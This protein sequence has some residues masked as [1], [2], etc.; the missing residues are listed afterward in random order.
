MNIWLVTTGSSDVQLTNNEDWNDWYRTIKKSIQRLPFKPTRATDDENEPYRLPARVLGIAY[1]RL[2]EAI[3]PNLT[4]PLLDGFTQELK[5][6]A[7][8]ITQIIVLM[9]DQADV[10]PES[11]RDTNRSP[12]W[13]DTCLLYPILE[14]YFCEHFPEALLT[15]LLLKPDSVDRG[16]DNWDAVLG[17]VQREIRSLN[18]EPETVYVSHQAGTPAISSAVQ[19]ASL[20]K[21]GDRVKFLVSSEYREDRTHTIASSKY[22]GA[23]RLQEAKA[24]LDRYDYA[25]VKVLIGGALDTQTQVFLDAGIQW[26][27]ADFQSFRD[28]LLNSNFIKAEDFKWWSFGYESAYLAVIRHRQGSIVDALFHSFRSVEGLI[29]IWAETTYKDYIVY[30]KKG[31]PQVTE[32]IKDILPEYWERIEEKQKKWLTEQREK[33]QQSIDKGQEGLPLSTG[34]FSQSLY[35][36]FETVRPESK[37]NKYIKTVLYSAKDERNQQFHRLLGLQE[38]NLFQAWKA[39]N[40]EEWNA[41]LLG[42]L[43]FIAQVDSTSNFES[44]KSTSFMAKVHQ[45]LKDTIASL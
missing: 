13:Q 12:Y 6:Q 22:L 40:V 27:L 15:P 20:A 7:V 19:F 14:R 45:E 2:A 30:D 33:N 25:G 43:N 37:K 4:F 44:I 23:I 39:T 32:R 11:E 24:L 9:S 36:L 8:E 41:V 21:F 35:M 18:I 26:N 5:K 1:D 42:C 29:C 3:Q 31:S 34:L 10:F 16:L 17:L 38:E 28:L